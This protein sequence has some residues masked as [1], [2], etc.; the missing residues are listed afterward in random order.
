M[1]A[2]IGDWSGLLAAERE[3]DYFKSLYS[4]LYY[5]YDKLQ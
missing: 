5:L 1:R 3:M 2:D 4:F